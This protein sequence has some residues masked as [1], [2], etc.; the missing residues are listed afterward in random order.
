MSASIMSGEKQFW[1]APFDPRFPNTNQTKNCWQNYLDYH[2]CRKAKGED[3]APC[4]YFKRVY[5]SIC[6]NAWTDKWDEQRE[7]GRFPGKI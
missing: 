5:N 4:E 1:T 6:P 2:R 3:Y 7:E